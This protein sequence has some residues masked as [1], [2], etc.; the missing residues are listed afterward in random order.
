MEK[1]NLNDMS[2]VLSWANRT[3]FYQSMKFLG[4]SSVSTSWFCQSGFRPIVWDGVEVRVPVGFDLY[5]VTPSNMESGG[6]YVIRKP[7]SLSLESD[8]SLIAH[9]CGVVKRPAHMLMKSGYQ[10][11]LLVASNGLQGFVI[12]CQFTETM[13]T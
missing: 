11:K 6:R 8:D 4:V 5:E 13:K 12:N 7:E 3:T 2:F 9:V 1:N 10:W